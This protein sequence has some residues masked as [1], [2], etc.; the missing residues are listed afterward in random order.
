MEFVFG[1]LRSTW[2]KVL[3]YVV[4]GIGINTAAPHY[5]Q[6]NQGFDPSAMLHSLAQYFVSVML[7]PLSFW[8]PTFTVGKWTGL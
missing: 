4:L 2:L 3:L 6:F 5:P 7:W 1:V 8:Q